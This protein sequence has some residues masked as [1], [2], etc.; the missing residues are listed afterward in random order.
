MT[1]R[2]PVIG[3]YAPSPSGDLHIGNVRTA[4]LA[5]AWARHQG[6]QFLLRVEDIDSQRSSPQAAQR[7]IADLAALGLDFDGP[8]QYQSHHSAAYAAALAQLETYECYCSRAEI[9]QA[10]AA[11][12]GIPGRYPGTCRELSSQQRQ[13]RREALA[14]QGRVPA[15]RLRAESSHWPV[16]DE[17]AGRV[18]GEVDDFVLRRGGNKNQAQDWAYNLAVT[19]DDAASGVNQVVRGDDLLS[20][21]A[22]QAYL[23]HLLGAPAVHYIH[24]PLVLGA[25]GARLAKRD[26]AVTVRQLWEVGYSSADIIAV[27]SASVYQDPLRPPARSAAEFLETFSPAE[28]SSQPYT[29]RAVK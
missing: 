12:H 19:V 6:G 13:Q 17:F 11:P 23:G 2:A 5:W 9:Q 4:L 3:R 22:R 15:L 10:A 24:V 27:L 18:I 20:S 8:V 21:A 28:V 1:S 25:S 26:G 14:A 16:H 29:W 7:Q